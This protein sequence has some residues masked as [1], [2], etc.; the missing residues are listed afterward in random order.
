[1]KNYF[2]SWRLDDTSTL[3][4]VSKVS[5]N[6]NEKNVA[7]KVI[8]HEHITSHSDSM[9]ESSHLC[10]GQKFVS[11]ANV[12]HLTINVSIERHIFDSLMDFFDEL[13]KM[14]RELVDTKPRYLVKLKHFALIMRSDPNDMPY[15]Q[16]LFTATTTI[17]NQLGKLL[18]FPV[19]IIDK[20][21]SNSMYST[22]KE[23]AFRN[24]KN[25]SKIYI[26]NSNHALQIQKIIDF[27]TLK[28][29]FVTDF[30]TMI[31]KHTHK[32]KRIVDIEDYNIHRPIDEVSIARK[33]LKI[34]DSNNFSNATHVSTVCHHPRIA[35]IIRCNKDLVQNYKNIC[36]LLLMNF[37]FGNKN[38]CILS[39]TKKYNQCLAH[40]TTQTEL[41]LKT[42]NLL[43]WVCKDVFKIILGLLHP[44][45][46]EITDKRKRKGR[47][48]IRNPKW[49]KNIISNFQFLQNTSLNLTHMK[50]QKQKLEKE[51]KDIVLRC[52]NLKKREREIPEKLAKLED[53]LVLEKIAS[54]KRNQEFKNFLRETIQKH[55]LNINQQHKSH[56]KRIKI[57]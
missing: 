53:A 24:L 2:R 57:K 31:L 35:F 21:L 52:K 56:K 37:K 48:T 6:S 12:Q 18:T 1:M 7:Y 13:V 9:L 49:A 44:R 29:T 54:A 45:D 51:K 38:P 55:K 8:L 10:D 20:T 39:T 3:S 33:I 40:I 5:T 41:T 43:S 50:K 30:G 42:R 16:S 14:L 15:A 19:V 28:K 4:K 11:L 26:A 17:L 47:L 25:I 34:G 32:Y 46:W 27:D 36:T 22:P 23:I